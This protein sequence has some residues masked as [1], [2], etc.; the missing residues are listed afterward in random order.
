MATP[1]SAAAAEA[2]VPETRYQRFKRFFG[3]ANDPL[4]V[5]TQVYDLG[6]FVGTAR[7][8]ASDLDAHGINM[9]ASD[10]GKYRTIT[11]ESGTWG[12]AKSF[13]VDSRDPLYTDECA[14]LSPPHKQQLVQV[15]GEAAA[16]AQAGQQYSAT[17]VGEDCGSVEVFTAGQ[18][19]CVRPYSWSHDPDEQAEAEEAAAAAAEKAEEEAYWS[20]REAFADDNA[21]QEHVQERGFD[22]VQ[23]YEEFLDSAAAGEA[24]DGEDEVDVPAEDT[25]PAPAVLS[26]DQ[27]GQLIADLDRLETSDRFDFAH[28]VENVAEE[29]PAA[30]SGDVAM[31]PELAGLDPAVAP[32]AA[33]PA[34]DEDTYE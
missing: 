12:A 28:G 27:V 7:V 16:A 1:D 21:Y 3:S 2:A 15:L 29:S 22:T 31:S 30:E 17:V 9:I 11:V 20:T 23:E 24:A 34:T 4:H 25:R 32:V 18:A 33:E 19:V 26:T 13:V 14:V 10:D 5:G 8:P 6:E